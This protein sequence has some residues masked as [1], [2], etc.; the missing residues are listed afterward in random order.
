MYKIGHDRTA[1]KNTPSDTA[2]V[3]YRKEAIAL[4]RGKAQL[5]QYGSFFANARYSALLGK[6]KLPGYCNDT[7][8]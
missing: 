8:E 3:G 5:K 1:N 4:V 7:F 2:P 6:R